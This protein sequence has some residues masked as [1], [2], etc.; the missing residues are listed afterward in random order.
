MIYVYMGCVTAQMVKWYC[1]VV[2]FVCP[3]N[4]LCHI[5]PSKLVVTGKTEMGTSIFSSLES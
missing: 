4:M 3:V 1:T 2:F 5:F